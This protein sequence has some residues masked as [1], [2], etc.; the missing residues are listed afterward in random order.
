MT[1][2]RKICQRA[3]DNHLETEIIQGWNATVRVEGAA[4]LFLFLPTQ[5]LFLGR[6]NDRVELRGWK[7]PEINMRFR[8]FLGVPYGPIISFGKGE[9]KLSFRNLFLRSLCVPSM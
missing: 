3:L 4:K 6:K 5:V 8:A 1:M 9:W 2:L 7:G